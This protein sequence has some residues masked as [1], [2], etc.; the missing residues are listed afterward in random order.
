MPVFTTALGPYGSVLWSGEPQGS[1]AHEVV[2][3][4][5]V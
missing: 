1:I 2:P 5:S 3:V 4:V